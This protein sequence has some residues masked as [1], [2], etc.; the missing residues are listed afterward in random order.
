[1]RNLFKRTSDLLEQ[2]ISKKRFCKFFLVLIQQSVLMNASKQ[3]SLV[4]AIREDTIISICFLLFKNSFKVVSNFT[5][6]KKK[7]KKDLLQAEQSSKN[8]TDTAVYRSIN[9]L[10]LLKKSFWHKCFPVNFLR[11]PFLQ[12]T[13]VGCFCDIKQQNQQFI[14]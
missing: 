2:D 8:R 10:I 11:T 6:T 13:S 3:S 7:Q 9:Q 12:S 5:C 4:S 1:M 14:Y